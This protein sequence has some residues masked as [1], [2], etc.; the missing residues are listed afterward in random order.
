MYFYEL[1]NLDVRTLLG[2]LFW[3]SFASAIVCTLNNVFRARE[4]APAIIKFVTLAKYS[5]FI[6]FYLFFFRGNLPDF[7]SS[8]CGNTLVMIGFYFE[9]RALLYM[10]KRETKLNTIILIVV[11]SF[12]ATAYNV[13]DLLIKSPSLRVVVAS[14]VIYLILIVPSVNLIFLKKSGVFFPFL[15]GLYLFF[16]CLLLPRIFISAMDSGTSLFTNNSVQSLTFTA[17]LMIMVFSMTAFYI[18]FLEERLQTERLFAN[19]DYL[20]NLLNRMSFFKKAKLA[21]EIHFRERL[22]YSL[23]II[24]VDNFKIINIQYGDIFA[25]A[26]LKS[27]AEIIRRNLE[28]RD[29]A[30]RFSGKEFASLIMYRGEQAAQSALKRIFHEVSELKFEENPD[31]S[32][33]VSIGVTYG[34]PDA[35]NSLAD[36]V[37]QADRCLFE[38]KTNS[39]MKIINKKVN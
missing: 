9:A 37:D 22:T 2:V 7:L 25:D 36:F 32:I 14:V 26:V 16:N 31:L 38:A 1:I 39:D 8:N 35:Q 4:K 15:G 29:L 27:V 19:Y 10:S 24:S 3:V 21:H 30:C 5:Q 11:L 20:T 33:S 6:A 13:L 18:V 34:I 28:N 23:A 17:H 12:G